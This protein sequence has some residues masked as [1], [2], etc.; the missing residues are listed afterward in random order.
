MSQE[1]DFKTVK[2]EL[3]RT[4]AL[5]RMKKDLLDA[6]PE[7]VWELIIKRQGIKFQVELEE[8]EASQLNTQDKD[9]QIHSHHRL[10]GRW[11]D[12]LRKSLVIG[13]IPEINRDV[14]FSK[15]EQR[16]NGNVS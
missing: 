1:Y 12:V 3:S 13:D 15:W 10:D 8:M 14:I 16:M 4:S 2:K 9:L 11:E 5:D 7:T 6:T